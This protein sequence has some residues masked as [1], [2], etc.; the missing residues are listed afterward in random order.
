MSQQDKK[1]KTTSN[2]KQHQGQENT[3]QTTSN[4]VGKKINKERSK[5]DTDIK[6]KNKVTG[7]NHDGPVY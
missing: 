7:A 1:K 5:S 2:D 4:N 3:Q 6:V